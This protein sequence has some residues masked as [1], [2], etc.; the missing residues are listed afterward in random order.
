MVSLA[1]RDGLRLTVLD[2]G[3]GFDATAP[4]ATGS[5]GLLS[6][7]ERAEALGGSLQVDSRPGAT[8]LEVHLP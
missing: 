3:Q 6:M 8:T 5:F 2:D 4:A 7:R 1:S